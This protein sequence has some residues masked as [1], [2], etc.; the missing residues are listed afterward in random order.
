[1]TDQTRRFIAARLDEWRQLA[2][3]GT[4]EIQS[5]DEKIPW[6]CEWVWGYGYNDPWVVTDSAGNTKLNTFS[7]LVNRMGE[8]KFI[9]TPPHAKILNAFSP[10]TITALAEVL[11]AELNTAQDNPERLA[12][13]AAIWDEHPDYPR[14]ELEQSP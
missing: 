12:S 3:A 13:I 11:Q 9:Q 6:S 4:A 7:V 14:Q 8:R 1:M 10:T 5:L 2:A